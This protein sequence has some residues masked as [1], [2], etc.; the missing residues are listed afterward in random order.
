[1]EKASFVMLGGCC[2]GGAAAASTAK[3]DNWRRI[4]M[5]V[6]IFAIFGCGRTRFGLSLGNGDG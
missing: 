3:A 2:E 4:A 1:M 6:V 5:R